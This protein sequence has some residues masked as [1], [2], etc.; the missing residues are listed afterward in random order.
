MKISKSWIKAAVIHKFE[1]GQKTQ[2]TSEAVC[3]M[4]QKWFLSILK[5]NISIS[6]VDYRFNLHKQNE[7]LFGITFLSFDQGIKQKYVSKN[8][9][10]T[11]CP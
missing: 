10:Q 7:Y 2:G 8:S 3:E 11:K 6:G 4:F 9:F 5:M 1:N